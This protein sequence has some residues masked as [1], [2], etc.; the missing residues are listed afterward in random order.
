MPVRGIRGATTSPGNHS[1]DLLGRTKELLT[2]IQKRNGFQ[3]EEL[4]SIVFTTTPDLNAAF[5]A[6]AAR[7]IGW[8]DTA[9]LCTHEIDVAGSIPRCIRVLILWN[10]AR[11][12][13]EIR[14]VYL[15]EAESLRPDLAAAPAEKPAPAPFRAP[16]SIAFQG[17]HGAFS[18]EAILLGLGAETSRIPCRTFQEICLAVTSSRAEAGLLPVENSTTGSIHTSYDLLLENDLHIIGEYILPVRE[19][20]MLAPGVEVE[21]VRQV[22]SHPQALE[23][24]AR[25]IASQH[26]E[27][28]PVY[29]TA[30]AAR[31]LAQEKRPDRAA[32]ASETAARL[33]GLN[34]IARSIQ[35][36]QV[37]YT[38]FLLL[39]KE[40]RPVAKPAKTS[41]IF[42]TRHKPGALHAC[43]NVLARRGINLCKIESRPDRKKPWH[44]LFYLDFEG[45]A[46]D[47]KV[48]DVLAELSTH[49]EFVRQ[50]GSYPTRTLGETK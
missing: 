27:A 50:L 26:W 42:A 3:P 23:Q 33:Y 20:A 39:A 12:P 38:R 49:T 10:T 25:W 11:S 31:I 15:H 47:P 2:E 36:I 24:C 19:C 48:I 44:Y 34:V 21:T 18:E 30:G 13:E 43:L 9:M 35:D 5:P 8:N 16:V 4:A 29:D 6:T 14:H 7:E 40:N 46:S 45:D 22:I 32:I 37:N 41:L 28:V 1:E 17:E